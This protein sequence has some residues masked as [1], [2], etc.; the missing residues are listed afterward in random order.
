M[1]SEVE[2]LQ[3]FIRIMD[4]INGI[5]MYDR[6]TVV[7][8]DIVMTEMMTWFE[9]IHQV[10]GLN[11]HSVSEYLIDKIEQAPVG[12]EEK[13]LAM[14]CVFTV[15]KDIQEPEALCHMDY[16]FLNVM[17]EDSIC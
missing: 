12:D 6:L 2:W 1:K 13:K 3:R 5:S 16:H 9:K 11:L 17:Y 8:K 4:L 10:K 15:E 7:G 14:Q